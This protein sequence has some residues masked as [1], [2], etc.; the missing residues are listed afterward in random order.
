MILSTS[1]VMESDPLE[2]NDF[3]WHSDIRAVLM[4]LALLHIVKAALLTD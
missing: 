3:R 4:M 1:Y 2:A